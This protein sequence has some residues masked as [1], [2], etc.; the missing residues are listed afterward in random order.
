M[1]QTILDR[2]QRQSGTAVRLATMVRRL[3]VRAT[4]AV[5]RWQL[6]GHVDDE[7]NEEVFDQVP[8]YQQVGFVIQKRETWARPSGRCGSSAGRS[9]TR[10]IVPRRSTAPAKGRSNPAR[11]RIRLDLPIPFAPESCSA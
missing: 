10:P 9:S 7:G 5:N 2:R 8:V 11:I 4:T 3:V 1:R 6:A